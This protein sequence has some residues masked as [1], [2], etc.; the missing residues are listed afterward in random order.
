MKEEEEPEEGGGGARGR[1]RSQRKEEP[2]GGVRESG[3]RTNPAGQTLSERQTVSQIE[4]RHVFTLGAHNSRFSSY[5]GFGVVVF[6][7]VCFW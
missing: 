7:L 2:E 5:H 4:E 1:R 6:G 3:W